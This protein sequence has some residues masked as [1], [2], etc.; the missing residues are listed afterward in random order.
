SKHVRP[1]LTLRMP[2]FHFTQEQLNTVTRGFASLDKVP[3]P[4]PTWPEQDAAT[5]ASGHDLFTRWQC[6]KCHVV[7][8]KLPNQAPANMAPDLANV[9][10]RLR[11]DWLTVWLTDPGRIQPGTRMPQ[12]FPVDP[13][14][15]AY[16]DVL[17][18]DQKKQIEA[19]RSYLLTLGP[20]PQ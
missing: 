3:Y 7:A 17:G 19:V 18:G 12:A 9:P 6:I 8:G 1:W 10:T 11:P 20:A 13:N 2:T 16:P 14:E 5:L 4:Y 15:N